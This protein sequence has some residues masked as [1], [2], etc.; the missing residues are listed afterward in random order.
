MDARRIDDICIAL[1]HGLNRR[2]VLRMLFG[3]VAAIPVIRGSPAAA[4]SPPLTTCRPA[5]KALPDAR[6]ALQAPFRA[7]RNGGTAPCSLPVNPGATPRVT[8]PYGGYWTHEDAFFNEHFAVDFGTGGKSFPVLAAATGMLR[9]HD[10]DAGAGIYIRHNASWQTKY[11]HL[12]PDC[13]LIH[14]PDTKKPVTSRDPEFEVEVG[15]VIGW[16]LTPLDE[17]PHLHFALRGG[18]TDR[19]T[20]LA[21]PDCCAN[22]NCNWSYPIPEIATE[23]DVPALTTEAC[24]KP[25]T[26]LEIDDPSTR[27]NACCAVET[28][29]GGMW[30]QAEIDGDTLTLAA[31]LSDR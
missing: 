17:G 23:L 30:S 16:V 3:L 22:A 6:P 2:S 1:S 10:D 18:S 9:R 14:H 4:Q 29:P 5:E 15:T 12:H 13:G 27:L 31:R 20:S 11:L 26:C 25:A 21:S 24:A 7:V 8:T 19:F 28:V